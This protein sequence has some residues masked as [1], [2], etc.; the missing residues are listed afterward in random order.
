MQ[1]GVENAAEIS[2]ADADEFGRFL[3]V[4]VMGTFHVT[5]AVSA[6]MASQEPRYDCR[7]TIVNMGSASSFVSTPGMT[8]YTTSKHAVLGLTKNAGLLFYF[9]ST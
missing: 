3:Q 8:Q 1:I 2:N 9:L 6:I 4:N 7:G 5:R